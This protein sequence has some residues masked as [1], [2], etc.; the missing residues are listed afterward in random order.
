[1]DFNQEKG[2][3]DQ[4][5]FYSNRDQR[6]NRDSCPRQYYCKNCKIFGHSTERCRS[7]PQ[8]DSVPCNDNAAYGPDHTRQANRPSSDHRSGPRQPPQL[9]SLRPPPHNNNTI[10]HVMGNNCRTRRTNRRHLRYVPPPPPEQEVHFTGYNNPFTQD[11]EFVSDEHEQDW[12]LPTPLLESPPHDEDFLN[13]PTVTNYYFG[14][15]IDTR[16]VDKYHAAGNTCIPFRNTPN[17]ALSAQHRAD[18]Y[19]TWYLDSCC[20]QQMVGSKRFISNARPIP[21]PTIVSVANN[22]QLAA[23]ACGIVVLKVLDNKI[24]ITLNDVLIVRDLRHNL[25]SY[26]QLVNSGVLMTTDPET[27]CILMHWKDYSCPTVKPHYIGKARADNDVYILD[28]DVP[29]CHADSGDPVDLQPQL[30]TDPHGLTHPDGR[31]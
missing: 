25:L 27:R 16:H 20:R 1:M 21:E 2:T 29:D 10:R 30:V 13:S 6:R 22:Q 11:G 23:R 26:E 3:R 24:H 7:R 5:A 4:I 18:S 31:P 15:Y 8:H 28:F 19:N 17:L 9:D 14:H 12:D